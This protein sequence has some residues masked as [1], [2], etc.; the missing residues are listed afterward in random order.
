MIITG[1]GDPEMVLLTG[2]HSDLISDMD[3]EIPVRH[4]RISFFTMEPGINWMTL[5]FIFHLTVI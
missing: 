5:S 3:S 2:S 4:Q 1:I